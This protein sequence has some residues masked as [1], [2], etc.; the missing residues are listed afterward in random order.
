VY[1][2]FSVEKAPSTGK[3]HCQSYVRYGSAVAVTR[4]VKS[5][6]GGACGHVELAKGDEAKNI[7]YCSKSDTH[8]SGPFEHGERAQQGKRTDIAA[9]LELVK[10]GGTMRS[11][12][13]VST[14]YQSMR[15]AQLMLTYLEKGWDPN[16]E[17]EVRWYHGS[18]GSGKTRSAFEEFPDAWRSS[19]TGRWFDGY[20]GHEVAILDDV[21]KDFCE[22]HVW[23]HL[24]DRYPYRVEYKG[25]FRQWKPRIIIVTCPWAP[26]VLWATQ[27]AEPLAQLLRRIKEV[28]LF[29]EIV[30]PPDAPSVGAVAPHFRIAQN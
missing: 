18:T 17:R 22:F 7:E 10:N 3:L 19:K 27:K 1:F 21:R 11:I 13:E 30:P 2:I 8:V 28:R 23:L 14:S 24:L 29:G 15:A 26:E 4:V 20:D 6:G 9:T 5:I 25:G 16:V 12:I